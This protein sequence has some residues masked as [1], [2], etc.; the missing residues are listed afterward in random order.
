MTFYNA[1]TLNTARLLFTGYYQINV[2]SRLLWFGDPLVAITIDI[3]CVCIYGLTLKLE[4]YFLTLVR[5]NYFNN[6]NAQS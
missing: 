4:N 1:K 3:K 2:P 5:L 6:A